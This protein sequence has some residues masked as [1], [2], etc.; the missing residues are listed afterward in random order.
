VRI[1]RDMG[2]KFLQMLKNKNAYPVFFCFHPI[3]GTNFSGKL[4]L[5]TDD[6]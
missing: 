3:L 4:P 1:S 6:C 2:Q 5:M